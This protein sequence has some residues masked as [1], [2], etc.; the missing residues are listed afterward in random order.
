MAF[1]PLE[2]P[3]YFLIFE[4]L[5]F[6]SFV[7]ILIREIIQRR[8]KR[9]FE[10]FSCAAFGMILEIGNTYLAHTYS[11]SDIFLIK[12]FGVPLAIGLGWAVIIYCAML[13]SDQYNIPWPLRPFFD[14]L[15][16]FILDISMDVIAIRLGFWNWAI[17]LNQEW[18]GVPFEN[19]VGWIFVVFIFSFSIRFLR[20]LNIKRIAT[21]IL[22][23]LNPII[24]YLW[25]IAALAVY[26]LVAIF[27]YEINNWANLL[28]FNYHPNFNVLFKPEVQ[29]WKQ[30]FLIA[31]LVQLV[32]LVVYTIAKYSKNFLK[33]FDIVSFSILTGL[34]LFFLIALFTSG[35]YKTYPFFIVI[36]GVAFAV[37]CLIHFL[38][39]L[40]NHPAIYYFQEKTGALKKGRKRLKK[41]IQTA[42]Q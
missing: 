18:Y 36:G 28:S 42:L 7:I 11:Y 40:L 26:S 1:L 29:L 35:I 17:P 37:H 19:L 22:I 3:V 21:K 16:A 23:I 25:L 15:T 2:Q 5:G 6:F 13:L 8:I 39:Y 24:C 12:L 27:P 33:N 31:L 30:I 9:V 10:I 14:A 20:T 34:H 38:P 32:N 41:I 4:A